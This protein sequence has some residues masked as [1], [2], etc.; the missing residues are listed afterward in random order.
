MRIP[1]RSKPWLA[2]CILLLAA[3]WSQAF[4]SLYV[5]GDSLSDSGNAALAIGSDATQ[6]I[7]GNSYVPQQ[8]YASGTFSNGPVWV[9][10]FAAGLGLTVTPSLI[11]G[12]NFAFG[13]A[14]T[15]GG[16]APSLVAQAGNLLTNANNMLPGDALYVVAGGG[17][18]AR[19]ALFALA[20]GA[21]PNAT[22]TATV[23]TYVADVGGI[24]DSLQ[25]A[26][27]RH[28]VV[29][30]TPN[31][32]LTPFAASAGSAVQQAGSFLPLQMNTALAERLA[33]EQ[34]VLTFD[35]FSLLTQVASFPASAGLGNV[36]DA[37][38]SP[39]AANCDLPTALFWDGI[40]P[41][42]AGHA[43]LTAG[44]LTTVAAIPEP[45]T[46][47]LMLGGLALL[48]GV[49]RHRPKV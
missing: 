29:W 15:S 36:T 34:G 24:V 7:S 4:S 11:G 5:F 14:R 33:G 40:H 35:V 27:A 37:C 12:T 43:I 30:N 8:P 13:G 22:I 47:A 48:A 41:T 6:V 1:F 26:G 10:G 17:N 31:L 18:N 2:G 19:D 42:S 16:A 38:G 9:N 46:Y 49:A 45:Q 32:G 44:M 3:P 28:I 39:T 20:G 21:D 25:A 23:N